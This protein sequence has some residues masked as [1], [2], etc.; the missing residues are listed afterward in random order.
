[1]N[2]EVPSLL[3]LSGNIHYIH[4][5]QIEKQI[6]EITD[7]ANQAKE[8]NLLKETQSTALKNTIEQKIRS[9]L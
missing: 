2:K 5:N 8:L 7:A 3:Y 9:S 4:A 1:L 6:K